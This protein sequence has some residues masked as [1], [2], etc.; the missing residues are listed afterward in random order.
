ME[1][2]R[3]YMLRVWTE[4]RE[5]RDAPAPWRATLED[6]RSGRRWGFTDPEALVAFLAEECPAAGDGKTSMECAT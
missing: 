1:T 5:E 4:E 6:P 2:G 3:I